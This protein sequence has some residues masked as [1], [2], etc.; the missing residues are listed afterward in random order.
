MRTLLLTSI[1][2]ATA[3][4]GFVD[5]E[6][7]PLYEAHRGAASHW[8]QN[9]R[10]AMVSS[11][12]AGYD[13]LE[14]DVVLTADGVPILAHDPWFH[15]PLCTWSD[16]TDITEDVRID[17]LT[18]AEVQDQIL[19]G[20]KTDPDFPEAEVLAEPVMTVAELFDFLGQEAS[21][22]LLVHID[23]KYEPGL[24]PPP[25][26]FATAV[27][28]LW[29]DADLPNDFYVSANTAEAIG[30]FEQW[31]RDNDVDVPTSIAWPTF[32]PDS[33]TTLIGLGNEFGSAAGTVDL[34]QVIRAAEADGVAATHRIIDRRQVEEVVR[35]G[36]FVS[37]WTINDPGLLK[38]YSRFPVRSL[39]TDDPELRP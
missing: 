3:G 38:A 19:C 1:L 30:A 14:F 35:N 21:P 23:I 15:D 2:L 9:S 17:S 20:G 7:E 36:Y 25:E 28:P 29:V 11:V 24:T 26:D 32:P 37:L 16:G 10:N 39:I 18:A 5:A 13:A 12:R 33:N 27:M 4:C 31:G 6:G 34:V 8:A 22:D